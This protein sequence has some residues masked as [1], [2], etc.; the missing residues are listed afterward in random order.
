MKHLKALDEEIEAYDKIVKNNE[1]AANYLGV[2]V[3]TI[4]EHISKLKN[5][6][7][8]QMQAMQKILADT[9]KKM[10][11]QEE[12]AKANKEALKEARTKRQKAGKESEQAQANLMELTKEGNAP[13]QILSSHEQQ[14]QEESNTGGGPSGTPSKWIISHGMTFTEDGGPSGTLMTPKDLQA[15]RKRGNERCRKQKRT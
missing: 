5:V 14:Q 2:Q 8:D 6:P 7:E 1:Q 11:E 15:R 9:E 12:E 10:K 13:R 4:S 3:K